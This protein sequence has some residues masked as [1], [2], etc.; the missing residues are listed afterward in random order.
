[1]LAMGQDVTSRSLAIAAARG[2]GVLAV[3]MEAVAL[4]TFARRRNKT[5]LCLA[6]VTKTM[7]LAGQDFKKGQAQ[8]VADALTILETVAAALRSRQGQR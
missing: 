3:E 2:K 7:G 4:Y 5:V 1:M 6:Q 8:G